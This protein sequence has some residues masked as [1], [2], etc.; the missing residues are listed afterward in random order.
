MEKLGV[1]GMLDSHLNFVLGEDMKTE[2]SK[3]LALQVDKRAKG[4]VKPL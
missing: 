4:T 3:H 1:R 2:V